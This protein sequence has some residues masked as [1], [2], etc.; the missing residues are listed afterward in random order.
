MVPQ[1][2][3]TCDGPSKI[4]NGDGL[5]SACCIFC[6]DRSGSPSS[7]G[8]APHGSLLRRLTSGP[9]AVATRTQDAMLRLLL[10]WQD[11]GHCRW[12]RETLDLPNAAP[13]LLQTATAEGLRQASDDLQA[14]PAD[15][16][17][18]LTSRPMSPGSE[19][20]PEA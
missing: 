7:E 16:P 12:S 9:G 5:S 3:Q 4:Q 20:I 1:H 14:N 8:H 17:H 10:V 6:Y 18:I 19:A 2:D 11:L 13:G 15:E